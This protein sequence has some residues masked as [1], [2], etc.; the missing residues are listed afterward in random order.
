[1]QHNN[2]NEGLQFPTLQQVEGLYN[3]HFYDY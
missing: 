2:F 3:N 1:M